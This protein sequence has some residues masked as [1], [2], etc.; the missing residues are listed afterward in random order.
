MNKFEA[1][2]T[3]IFV[4]GLVLVA[5]CALVFYAFGWVLV[6]INDVVAMALTVIPAWVW[7]CAGST[8][9][10]IAVVYLGVRSFA[11]CVAMINK[12]GVVE[13]ESENAIIF[14]RSGATAVSFEGRQITTRQIEQP[15]ANAELRLLRRREENLWRI[16]REE[17]KRIEDSRRWY[18]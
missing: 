5:L 3:G 13:L 17:P 8:V 1:I 9:I 15:L 12:A 4:T 7:A 10:G 16:E 6:F 11:R 2:V 14:K 18:E